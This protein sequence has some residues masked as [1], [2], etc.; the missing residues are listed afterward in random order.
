MSK[1]LDTMPAYRDYLTLER[2]LARA[3]IVAY[4][5]DLN[6][7]Q[8]FTSKAVEQ[9]N[10]D[11]LRAYMRQLTANG[12]ARATVRRKMQGLSTYFKWM[13]MEHLVEEVATDGLIVP[14]R[15]RRVP[16]FLSTAQL[17]TF[18]DTTPDYRFMNAHRDRCAF[19]LLAFTGIRRG[20]L[21]NLQVQD[22]KLQEMMIIIR[23][24][25]GGNDRAVPFTDEKLRTDLEIVID[26]RESGWL[27][28]SAFGNR[29]EHQSFTSIFRK[30]VKSIGLDGVTPHTLRHTFATMLAAAGVPIAEIRD[31]LGHKEIR[32]TSQYMHSSPVTLRAAVSKHPLAGSQS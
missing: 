9:I 17:Q 19:R 23:E 30:H 11:D 28:L 29:W 7:L 18:L 4:T 2:Q 24:P 1:I 25:K 14:A 22:V 21:L 3:T 16:K 5:R 10:R 27:F 12:L 32:T 15:K 31:L 8:A 20:E 26:D 6:L 13:K